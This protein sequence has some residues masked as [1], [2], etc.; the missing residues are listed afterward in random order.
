MLRTLASALIAFFSGRT[1]TLVAMAIYIF[2][3]LIMVK[4][5]TDNFF[6]LNGDIW[7]LFL[8]IC[9]LSSPLS[10]IWLLSKQLNLIGWQGDKKG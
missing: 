6:C 9:L 2:L 5:K 7:N 1:R 8:Q 4:V 3:R 10:F